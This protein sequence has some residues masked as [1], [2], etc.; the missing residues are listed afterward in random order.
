MTPLQSLIT[1]MKRIMTYI[2]RPSLWRRAA[3]ATVALV[4]LC[5]SAGAAGAW[6][7]PRET[8]R[9]DIM[10]KWGLV[11]KKA[12]SVSVTA[13]P[14]GDRFNALLTG[15]TARWADRFYTVRDTLRGTIDHNTFLP[16]YYEKTAHEGGDYEHNVLRYTRSGNTT[17]ADGTV[18]R[19]RKKDAE[20]RHETK[21]MTA[22][23]Q[24]IDMLS[25]FYVM[26]RLD[27]GAMS[28][29][30]T[31]RMNVFSGKQKEILTI[32]Y[33]GLDDIEIDGQRRKC[34]HITFT[35]TSRNGKKTSDNMDAWLSTDSRRIPLLMEGKLPVGK[36]RAVFAG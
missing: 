15:A 6:R 22:D 32:H 25:A 17:T 4:A 3:L 1:Q 9:Y 33:E 26:R 5:G 14:A 21:T 29:G 28:P 18:A 30:E 20:T 36:V 24:T 35:F 16:V 23:G 10:Y 8:L 19:K 27:Y 13:T 7:V 2:R 34:Y 12:G 31:K 11:N